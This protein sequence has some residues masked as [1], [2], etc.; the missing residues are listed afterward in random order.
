MPYEIVKIC[1]CKHNENRKKL[2]GATL[3]DQECFS[4]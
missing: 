2:R 3:Y 1:S 4:N